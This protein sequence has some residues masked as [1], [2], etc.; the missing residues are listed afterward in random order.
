ML[1]SVRKGGK[2]E[3]RKTEKEG[4]EVRKKER[5]KKLGRKRGKGKKQQAREGGKEGQTR[6]PPPSFKSRVVNEWVWEVISK[7]ISGS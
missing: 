7:V 2:E 1:G 6:H 4:R 3:G 5:K